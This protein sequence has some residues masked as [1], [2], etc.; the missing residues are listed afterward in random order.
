MKTFSFIIL[1]FTTILSADDI[2]FCSIGM[3]TFGTS[4]AK[5]AVQKGFKMVAAFTRYS[6]HTKTVG[7]LLGMEND[8]S[9]QFEVS[10]M[11]KLEQII[12]STKPHFCIDA[13][14]S[15]LSDVF[16]HFR[17]LLA[18]GINIIT[19]N[20]EAVFPNTRFNWKPKQLYR[21][22]NTAAIAGNA[23]ILGGGYSDS[24]LIPVIPSMTAS[25][26][27]LN[28]IRINMKL[29]VDGFGEKGAAHFGVGMTEKEF[30]EN[31]ESF[32][33]YGI[34]YW[35][36]AVVEA[37]ADTMDI[38]LLDIDKKKG[39]IALYTRSECYKVTNENGLQSNA[40]GKVIP[41]GECAGMNQTILGRA[42]GN[43]E[44]YLSIILGVIPNINE[45]N[46]VEVQLL[47]VP[48]LEFSIKDVNSAVVT[49]VSLLHRVPMVLKELKPG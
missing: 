43:I 37:I 21:A 2:R 38:P 11:N 41:N 45:I 5:L 47:G 22:L 27:E 3:G 44:I 14:N 25:M 18:K 49:G 17:R 12:D 30:K 32:S 13:T 7:E 20:N 42:K 31:V 48:D 36:R 46:D 35:S 29:D 39:T 24:I 8:P 4:T 19:L 40:L 6:K 15:T 34:S 26:I 33:S 16:P 23:V 28:K 9:L 10:G 1:L